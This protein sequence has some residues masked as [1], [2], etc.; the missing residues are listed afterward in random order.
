MFILKKNLYSD[1]MFQK[2][3]YNL[4]TYNRII[5]IP[6][7]NI[8]LIK[9]KIYTIYILTQEKNKLYLKKTSGIL[10]KKNKMQNLT[11]IHLLSLKKYDNISICFFKESPNILIK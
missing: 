3:F 5:N 8:N 1:L 4:Y 2:N 7:F 11:N 10:I 6:R 9:H